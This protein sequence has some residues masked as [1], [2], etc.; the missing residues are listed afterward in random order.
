MEDNIFDKI[1]E[2]DLQKTMEKSYI[3]YAMSVIASRAL[4]DVRDGLKPVQRRVL[5]SMIELN[6]GPDKPHRKCA[7]IVGDTMGKYHPHGDSSIYGALVNMA[8]DWSTRYPLVDGHGNFG[9]VDGDGAA[10]MRYTEARLSKISME[11][12]ADINKDTVDFQPNFDE[13]EREP[14]V[15]PARYPNLLV[16]GT[17]G[18]AVGMA[19]NIPPHNLREVI[20]AVV[21]IIDNIIEEDRDTTIEELLEIVKGPDFPTGATILGTRGIEEAYRTGRG[22]IRVRAVTNIETLPN[23]KSRIIVTELPYLVNKARLIEKIAELVREKKIDGI[24]DLNDHSSREGMRI[25]ID[26]RKDANANVVLNQ[27]YKHTQL[28]DTFGVIMLCLVAVNGSLQPKV[29]TL[30]EMLKYYLAHQEDVV[31]RRTKYDLN[32]AQERAHILEGLLK[33]LDNIDEVIRIIRGSRSVQVAKQELMDRFEL[34]DV[35]A[36]AIV[37]MRLRALTGL[38]REKL[39]AEYAELME[40]IRKLKA[41]LADRNTLLRV[42]REEILAISEKYGDDRRTAIGFDAYDISMEDMIPR[43]NTVITM[44][45]LGYIKRM[46]VDNFR[47][48][49]R[50]GRGIK[51]MQTLDDDYIEELMMTTTHHYVMFFTNTGRVY[52]L[53]AY[54]IPEAGRTARGTAIINLLQLMPGERIT[55][56]IPISKFEEDHYLMMATRKGLVKK[57]PIQDYA[58]VRKIGLAAISLRDDDE[59]IEVKATDDKKDIILVTKYGQCIR[60]KENDVRSTGRVSM[61]VRGINLLDGDEVVAMQLNTQGY[62]LL[63][64]SENG[65]GKR[66]SISEFTCQNRGGKGVK[67]YKITEKTGNVI[68]AKAVN[69]ENEIMMITTEGIIIRLQ[70]SDISILGRITS[71]VKLINL[72]E[73][74]TVASFAKV[75][76]KDEDKAEKESSEDT[77]NTEEISEDAT[78]EENQDSTEK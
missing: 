24:T 22:K 37:D 60:F 34:T 31:T 62:Y 61:G 48:Q 53:K 30:P 75:R 3:D 6:N 40:K 23:G 54:E 47:S 21:K 58:N 71:G 11:M 65:M 44:T 67:C 12:L 9:S 55:A 18:I 19:T 2:V 77:E 1:H 41:I 8:Q 49:N 76:E 51:G 46:T 17:S 28:Q 52:R 27:L 70:C 16:N 15:L 73:G 13:T 35:Q 36:Q 43:E 74:V 39:E 14:V 4:P 59:L 56:V 42:I 68:G 38:E 7:R 29:L 20:G 72:S 63:V 50:G 45:K 26:L 25:C 57:T 64:V 5:Y 78:I 10:A 32:K 66:T 69:E 33:A